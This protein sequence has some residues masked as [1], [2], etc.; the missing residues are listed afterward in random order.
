M[1]KAFTRVTNGHYIG[2]LKEIKQWLKLLG[3]F[4]DFECGR[5]GL[6]NEDVLEG[7]EV[8]REGEV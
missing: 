1:L 8:G 6:V 2:L 5:C 7:V 4:K 3:R